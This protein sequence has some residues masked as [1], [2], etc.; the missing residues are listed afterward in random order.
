MNEV[1]R[2]SQKPS[3]SMLLNCYPFAVES[4]IIGWN[5]IHL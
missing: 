3:Q 2:S 4:V 5:E 1:N